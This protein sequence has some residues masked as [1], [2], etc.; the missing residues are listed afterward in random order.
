MTQARLS[1]AT[2]LQ[3]SLSSHLQPE[4]KAMTRHLCQRFGRE[5]EAVLY[6]GS[7]LR[8]QIVD[9]LI[10]DFYVLV[11][12]YSHVYTRPWLAILNRMLPP[13]VFFV[14][15][16]WRSKILRA[17]VAV[18]STNQFL[19][20]CSPTYPNSSLWARFSQPSR[21]AYCRSPKIQRQVIDA[22][23]SAAVTMIQ[24]AL[25]FFGP[26]VSARSLWTKA[27]C[28][29][30]GAELRSENLSKPEEI[31]LLN[32]DYFETL[33]PFVLAKLR[34]AP[35]RSKQ[36]AETIWQRRRCLGKLTSLLRLLK[37]GLTFSGGIDY[38]AWKIERSSGVRVSLKP[39]QRRHPFLAAPVLFWSLYRKRAFR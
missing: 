5:T 22:V 34:H 25:P 9:G 38:L 36:S 11:D 7:C 8:N 32:R 27:L 28:L 3:R 31:Y 1:L 26:R 39:W 29:T 4:A 18:I 30:Y 33:T 10:M 21:L 24:N 37:A 13:N 16:H 17:K 12:D 20:R 23:E 2:I 6:Y 15:F 19:L 14:E 35:R